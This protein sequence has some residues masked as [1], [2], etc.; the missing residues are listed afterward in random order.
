MTAGGEGTVLVMEIVTMVALPWREGPDTVPPIRLG[1]VD[2][3][4]PGRVGEGV[5]SGGGCGT[6]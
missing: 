3:T 2:L 5:S 1:A 4:V 6:F